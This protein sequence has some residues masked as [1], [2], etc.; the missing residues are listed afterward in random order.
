MEKNRRDV[1]E[2]TDLLK[3]ILNIAAVFGGFAVVT[4]TQ[5]RIEYPG[6]PLFLIS[7]YAVLT[8]IVA[9]LMSIALITCALLLGA[10]LKNGKM[11]VNENAEEEYMFLCRDFCDLYQL[12]DRP[13]QPRR[14]F[15]AFW[16]IRCEPSWQLAFYFF[17]AGISSFLLSLIPIGWMVFYGMTATLASWF[18]VIGCA[19]ILWAVV[20]LSR[21]SYLR[22]SPTSDYL[23][24]IWVGG[25]GLPYDWHRSPGQTNCTLTGC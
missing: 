6:V 14:T 24:D 8:S 22:K 18:V 10:I 5:L 19:I 21:S 23:S 3:A 16:A 20:Q 17:Q 7:T 11:Y 4:L 1:E 12:G 2:K 25:V 13:P 9:G 15:E